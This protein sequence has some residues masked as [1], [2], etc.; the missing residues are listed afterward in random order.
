[1]HFL[2]IL[3]HQRRF[4]CQKYKVQLA[5]NHTFTCK[6]Q[7]ISRFFFLDFKYTKTLAKKRFFFRTKHEK[8][9]LKICTSE[10]G[11]DCFDSEFYKILMWAFDW[12]ARSWLTQLLLL[13]EVQ[14]SVSHA[15]SY[16]AMDAL[17]FNFH[18][19]TS[20]GHVRFRK[21]ATSGQEV[22][23]RKTCYLCTYNSRIDRHLDL[24]FDASKLDILRPYKSQIYIKNI[25]N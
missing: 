23:A 13:V 15:R 25:M 2:L 14:S 12:Y 3:M 19:F 4:F 16:G 9:Y 20:A 1:M 10:L 5:T 11:Y 21:I 18:Y 8:L 6:H 24:S 17:S 22:V 7:Q